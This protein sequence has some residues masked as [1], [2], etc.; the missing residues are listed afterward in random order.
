MLLIILRAL[1]F[2]S[3][4]AAKSAVILRGRHFFSDG[5]LN[6]VQKT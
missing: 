2:G 4:G 1:L 3:S 5:G 6:T